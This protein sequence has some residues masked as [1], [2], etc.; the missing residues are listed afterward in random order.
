MYRWYWYMYLWVW[1]FRELSVQC[2]VEAL[3]R[4]EVWDAARH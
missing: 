2:G 1:Q 4:A 3:R